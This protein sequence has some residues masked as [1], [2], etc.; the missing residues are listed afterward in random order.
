[1]V[2]DFAWDIH[3]YVNFVFTLL[4]GVSWNALVLLLLLYLIN[5]D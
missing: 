2:L 1:M 4:E 5:F 3:I